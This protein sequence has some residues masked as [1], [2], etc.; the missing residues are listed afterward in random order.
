MLCTPL[1]SS[2]ELYLAPS[3]AS[4][5]H[6][7]P[8]FWS[9]IELKKVDR[10]RTLSE[11]G[12]A[13]TWL[14]RG[15]RESAM[16]DGQRRSKST[17][18]MPSSRRLPRQF[19]TENCPWLGTQPLFFLDFYTHKRLYPRDINLEYLLRALLDLLSDH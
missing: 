4:P 13:H 8:C 12:D 19:V 2:P 16:Y 7:K 17:F 3:T 6:A 15:Q 18:L 11:Q 9:L 5:T 10:E 1:D 14:K